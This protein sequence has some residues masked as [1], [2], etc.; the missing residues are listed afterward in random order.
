MRVALWKW[1]WGPVLA[2]AAFALGVWFGPGLRE[3]IPFLSVGSEPGGGNDKEPVGSIHALGKLRPAKGVLLVVGPPGDRVKKIFKEENQEVKAGEPLVLLESAS[4]REEEVRLAELQQDEARKTLEAINKAEE[5]RLADI[6]LQIANLATAE[7]LEDDGHQVKIDL[8]HKQLDGARSQQSRVASLDPRVVRVS[9]QEQ[10]QLD[11]LVHKAEGELKAAELARKASR[12]QYELKAKAARAQRAVAVA[13]FDLARAKV[14]T[15]SLAKAVQLAKLKVERSTLK[16]PADGRVL[17]I[18]TRP[19][20]AVTT[21]PILEV[22][23]GQGME[24]LAE[25]YASEIPRLRQWLQDAGSVQVR[26]TSQTVKDLKLDGRVTVI[27]PM[28]GRNTIP[29]FGPRADNDRRVVEVRVAL[30][31]DGARASPFV[32]L[33]VDVEFL[34]PNHSTRKAASR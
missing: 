34:P 8:L 11:L 14:P 28:V 1:G 21:Q 31:E 33:E 17:R 26:I 30:P 4:D 15:E 22:G 29:G 5:T 12:E 9:A 18:I 32:G 2:A 25:V 27:S 19:G 6:D 13:E 3:H 23:A 20:D 24:V 7:K 10:E 16:A